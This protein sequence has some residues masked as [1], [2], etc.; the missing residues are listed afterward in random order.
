MKILR[1]NLVRYKDD[2]TKV[3]LFTDAYNVIFTHGPQFVLNKFEVSKPAR[4]IFGAEDICWP[5]AD[6]QV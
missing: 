3:I 1:E 5:D 2:K 6:L 4:I